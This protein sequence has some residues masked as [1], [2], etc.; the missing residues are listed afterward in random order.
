MAINMTDKEAW[1][2][3]RLAYMDFKR[4]DGSDATGEYINKTLFDLAKAFYVDPKSGKPL[5]DFGEWGDMTNKEQNDMLGEIISGKY[6]DLSNLMLKDYTPN[7]YEV[8]GF[9]A[10]AFSLGNDTVF[11]F[12]GSE[13]SPFGSGLVRTIEGFLDTDWLDNIFTGTKRISLQFDPAKAFVQK[14]KMSGETFVTA[15]SK[16]YITDYQ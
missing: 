2:L 5:N 6:P 15:H 16:G 11:A 9:F 8:T 13:G 1:I 10:Y 12:R 14:N 4:K 3:S 7:Q